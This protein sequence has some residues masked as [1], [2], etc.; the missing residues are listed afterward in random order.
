MYF[1]GGVEGVVF[2]LGKQAQKRNGEKPLSNANMNANFF[3]Y[4]EK[5]CEMCFYFFIL[6]ASLTNV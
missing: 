5:N 6:I 3:L 4:R 2:Y 1:K